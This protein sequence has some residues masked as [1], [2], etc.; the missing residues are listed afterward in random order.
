MT[1]GA[2]S[3]A[4]LWLIVNG[5]IS[6]LEPMPYANTV[7][8]IKS[9]CPI[10]G[11]VAAVIV[12]EPEQKPKIEG[13]AKRTKVAKRTIRRSSACGSRRQVWRTLPNGRKKYRC[14]R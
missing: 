4:L 11:P 1:P 3:A 9:A 12:P 14:Q 2:P 8:V 13:T 10:P 7:N 6:Q 5:C